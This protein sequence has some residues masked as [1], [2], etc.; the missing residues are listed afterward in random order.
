MRKF[1][2]VLA[3]TFTVSLGGLLLADHHE[4]KPKYKISEV[5]QKALKGKTLKDKVHSFVKSMDSHV[6]AAA[7]H[8]VTIGI[9]NHG[10]S[11]IHSPDSIRY[12]AEFAKSKHLGIALAPYHL[13]QEEEIIAKPLEQGVLYLRLA[14]FTSGIARRS[15]APIGS[16]CAHDIHGRR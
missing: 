2:P 8:G 12:F 9:E 13:P 7:K 4:K 14:R 10:H 5:M 1:V 15:S 11:L 6:A 3:L 16:R